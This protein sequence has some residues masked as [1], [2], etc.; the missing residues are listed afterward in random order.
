M[1]VLFC[2]HFVLL[3]YIIIYMKGLINGFTIFGFNIKFYGIIMATAILIAVLLACKNAKHR[4]LTSDNIFTLALFVIPLAL[5]GARLV[6]VLGADH[7]YTLIEVFKVWEGG[8]SI[9]GG[10]IGGAVAVVLYSIIYK[11]HFFD[12]ADVA[13]VSLILG[14]AIGR[15]GN[16]FN[17]EVYGALVTNPALKWFPF[18]VLL[19]SGEWH[20]ALFFYESMIN[21][22][23]FFGLLYM[24][25]KV[26]TRGFVAG[27][28]LVSYGLIRFIL[29]PLRMAEYNLMLWGIKLSSL[30]SAIA[31]VAG[32]VIL[33]LTYT[34]KRKTELKK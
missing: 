7:A 9:Y 10:I 18:A 8:M 23:I 25:K 29:E 34:I 26:K 31:I 28:Y 33:I 11:K 17:Q 16:F 3:V 12:L 32:I 14:Q 20:Y 6:Y 27:T 5:I 4:N 24:L 19:D 15:W 13:V 1:S 30:I 21:L 22:A 2:L